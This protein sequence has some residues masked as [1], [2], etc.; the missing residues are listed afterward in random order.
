M[1]RRSAG[2]DEPVRTGAS[3]SPVDGKVPLCRAMR[4]ELTR[5]RDLCRSPLVFTSS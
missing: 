1:E 4:S 5:E 3:Q 2:G